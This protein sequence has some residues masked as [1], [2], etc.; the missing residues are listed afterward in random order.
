MIPFPD[1]YHY[2]GTFSSQTIRIQK[3]YKMV[4]PILTNPVWLHAPMLC[5]AYLFFGLF[6]SIPIALSILFSA[7]LCYQNEKESSLRMRVFTFILA[8]LG[9]YP[10]YWACRSPIQLLFHG[11]MDQ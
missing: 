4:W 7:R 1:N 3:A 8:I 10:Q 2:N 5:Q 9:L 6:M 11:S